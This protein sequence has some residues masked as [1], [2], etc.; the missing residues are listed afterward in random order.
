MN[1][2][3]ANRLCELRKAHNLSQEELASK[4]G[5]S[6]QAVS[7]WERS[8]SSPDTDN[9]IQLASLY[10]IS[11]DELLNG[12]EAI[13]LIEENK[14]VK[15]E[16]YP[17]QVKFSA[18]CKVI[19]DGNDAK[20]IYDDEEVNLSIKET[21]KWNEKIKIMDNT[22]MSVS[23]ILFVSIYLILGFTLDKGWSHYW[24]L[25]ILISVPSSVI[26]MIARKNIN[27][28][29]FELVVASL[30]CSI[31]MFSGLWHPLWVIFLTIPL[32][33][34]ISG[35]IMK[36]KRNPKQDVIDA[37]YKDVEEEND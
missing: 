28:F 30:Y 10:N 34:L 25:F 2:K 26:N 16:S 7:K 12:D 11:I 29:Q 13:S 4:L 15:T 21:L 3:T 35:L 37:F 19:I 8:E 1:I 32:F 36:N 9:L 6:R 5:V 23:A 14:E 33:R 20:V 18:D 27:H 24:F 17:K 31:C 22:V